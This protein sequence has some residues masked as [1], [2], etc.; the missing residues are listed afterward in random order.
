MRNGRSGTTFGIEAWG[1]AQ[2]APW[3]RLSLGAS[4]L[5][6]N[7]DVADGRVDLAPRNS[8]GAD[9]H[10]Q[11]VGN[12]QMDLLPKLRLT[13]DMRAVGKL[14]IAPDVGSYV[15]AG[16]RLGYDLTDKVELYLAGRN[17]LHR[18][19]AENGDPAAA[20]LAKRSI[21]VGTRLRF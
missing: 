20:Q 10:W 15:E 1:S 8:L 16:G 11:V 18:D 9:P 19:H 12:S 14:D 5:H 13:F 7:L 4:T 6:K 2:V 21:Y 3:W 17:L